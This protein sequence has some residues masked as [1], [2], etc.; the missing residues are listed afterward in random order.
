MPVG[1][2]KLGFTWELRDGD[3]VARGEG[4]ARI[5]APDSVRLDFFL[6]G[7]MG[8][9]AAVLIGDSLRTP[10]PEAARD[11]VP[12]PPLLWATLGRLRIPPAAD[13]LVR[14]DGALLRADIGAPVR[15]R[16]AFRGDTLDRLERIDDGRIQE[17]V[18][19]QSPTS[20]QYRNE[21]ARRTLSLVIQ[22]TDA[23]PAFDPSIWSF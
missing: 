11:L 13:T 18:Q 1:H 9:G 6:G 12:P 10:G 19:H 17:W 20:V 15:W 14:V 23:A 2:E 4:V 16:V 3:L 5:A 21:R 8:S 22:R 7:G